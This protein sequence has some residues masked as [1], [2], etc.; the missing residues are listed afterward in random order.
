ML[1]KI[2]FITFLI[3]EAEAHFPIILK[4]DSNASLPYVLNRPYEKS[5]AI[6]SQF[7][8]ENDIDVYQFTIEENDLKNGDVKILIGTLVPACEPLKNLLISWALVGPKQPILKELNDENISQRI[9][10][11][12]GMGTFLVQNKEQGKIWY[13]KYTSHYYFY[14]KRSVINLNQIGK[15]QIYVWPESNQKGDYVF[16]FGD[17]EMWSLKDVFQTLWL[18]PRLFFEAEIESENCKTGPMKF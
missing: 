7:D 18:Y 14:Q 4:Q 3:F 13:E 2:I 8:G 6:Y 5:I 10:I 9:K 12:K 15:Y 16:E 17:Q 1:L 11:E